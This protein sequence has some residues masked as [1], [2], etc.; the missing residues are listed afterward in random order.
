MTVRVRLFADI[1]EKVGE[2][3][4]ET[5]GE[6]VGEVLDNLVEKHPELEE[7]LFEDGEL[8]PHVNLMAD[9]E[10][11]DKETVTDGVEE[12]AVYP[13]VSGGGPPSNRR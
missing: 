7:R 3:E 11:A 5:E 13:P 1:R 10:S 12:V 4:I 2:Q 6:T 9:G 8:R